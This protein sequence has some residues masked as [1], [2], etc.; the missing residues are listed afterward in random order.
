MR[1]AVA[2]AAALL[3]ALPIPP[4]GATSDKIEERLFID[5]SHAGA[6]TRF[7][8]FD[9]TKRTIFD[10]DGDGIPE[11]IAQNDNAKTYVIR[12]SDG[13]VVSEIATIHPIGWGAR[14]L[15]DVAVG[16]VNGN[17]RIDLVIA[18]SVGYVT[19]YE[20]KAEQKEPDKLAWER[21][22][23]RAMDPRKLWPGI[24]AERPGYDWTQTFPG[25]DGGVY[26]A[27]ANGDGS[28][29]IFAQN[30]NMPGFYALNPNGD[31]RWAWNW[32]DGNA[33]PWVD[34]L[35][36]DG[37]LE[38]V[39]ASDGG[40][41]FVFDAS[42]GAPEGTFQT[43]GA[44]APCAAAPGAISVSPGVADLDGDGIKEILFG[45][46]QANGTEAESK[47]EGWRAAQDTRIY[48]VTPR[49]ELKWCYTADWLA[50]HV[51]MHPAVVD[52]DGDGRKDVLF[53]DWNT[54]GHKPG[55]WETVGPAHLFALSSTGALLWKRDLRI[56]WSNKDIAVADVD[57]DSNQEIL[58][59]DEQG[60]KEG[61]AIL[62]LSGKPEAFLPARWG[63]SRGPQ[64]A[65]LDDDGFL[66]IVLPVWRGATGC[67]ATFDVGCREG[68]LQV[69]STPGKTAAF[70]GNFLFNHEYETVYDGKSP[71][72]AGPPQ[73]TDAP[74]TGTLAGRVYD[75][76][77]AIRG[78]SVVARSN[79]R[80]VQG[81]TD[82]DGEF[83]LRVPAGAWDVVASSFGH[84]DVSGNVTTRGARLTR[85]DADL[86][87]SPVL[88][89]LPNQLNPT[90]APGFALLAFAA[91]V[92]ALA[93]SRLS[94][95]IRR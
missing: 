15:N 36:G 64:V 34:D 43:R 53:T 46:R 67:A 81:R 50:P 30:D 39:F 7:A 52:V 84:D 11:I 54:I 80:E 86:P 14:D 87:E 85:W 89:L 82:D 16:D 61:V 41:V 55:A 22:W 33:N 17:G 26:L 18:N 48:A 59:A 27:D 83:S 19:V 31:V 42:T 2:L 37:R 3:L 90:G 44:P 60:G 74:R 63:V 38:A 88:G 93:A 71:K 78:A 94:R 75:D 28:L 40:G 72:K 62:T 32:S 68:A 92:A 10:V 57:G 5:S 23:D 73:K 4:A 29:E 1:L 70:S 77:G 8:A 56:G 49:G 13:V 66:D 51:Y 76:D 69:W 58:V 24:E 25:M 21:L 79:G 95:T 6:S 35:D 45:A 20:L 47:S 65:D 9:T 12:G 91:A